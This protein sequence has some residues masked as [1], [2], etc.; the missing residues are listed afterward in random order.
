MVHKIVCTAEEREYRDSIRKKFEDYITNVQFLLQAQ[1]NRKT[2]ATLN[3]LKTREIQGNIKQTVADYIVGVKE[4][5]TTEFGLFFE[6]FSEVSFDL[7]SRVDE[8]TWK[9]IVAVQEYN[10]A[11]D[12]ETRMVFFLQ[13]LETHQLDVALKLIVL[14]HI[15]Q[16]LERSV[17]LEPSQPVPTAQAPPSKMDFFQAKL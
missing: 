4:L 8:T 14:S 5:A 11:H 17:G 12:F 3:Q 15:K 7:S 13:N 1:M 16:R 10:L 6:Y 2:G 9:A